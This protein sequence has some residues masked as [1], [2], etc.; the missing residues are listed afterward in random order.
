MIFRQSVL[1]LVPARGGSK[2]LPGKN[3]KDLCGKPL[4]H[5]TIEEARKSRYID[6]VAVTT[7]DQSIVD[8]VKGVHII[9]R[10]QDMAGDKS[11]VYDA[12]FHAL[13][14]LP[15][16]DWVCLLQPTSPLRIADDIDCCIATAHS[17]NSPSCISTTYGRPDANGAVYVAWTS[18]LRET[19]L[20]D[21]G[22]AVTYAMPPERSVDIDTME[23][24][25]EAEKLLRLSG[26]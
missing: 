15:P 13:D 5:W 4:I 9:D 16:F 1:G 20:F 24:F 8:S 19:R 11:S 6:T 23:D 10:P 18:W 17:Q 2:R 22:R 12:I 26:R 25:R 21:S 3:L 14:D 7:E